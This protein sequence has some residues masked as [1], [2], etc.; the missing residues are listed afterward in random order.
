VHLGVDGSVATGEAA[1][2]KAVIAN[3]G[4]FFATTKAL[5]EKQIA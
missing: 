5:L 3:D 4:S 2:F 1:V